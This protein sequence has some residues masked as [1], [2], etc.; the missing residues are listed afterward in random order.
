MRGFRESRLFRFCREQIESAINLKCVGADNLRANFPRDTSC[1]F[2]FS[3]C[4]RADDKESARHSVD[5]VCVFY[6]CRAAFTIS[7]KL[8]GSRLAP[9]TRAPSMSAWL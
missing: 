3:D 4:R 5:A 6:S 8:R 7:A 1:N 9:P 2:G